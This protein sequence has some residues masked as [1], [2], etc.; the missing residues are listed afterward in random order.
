V[1]LSLA[2]WLYWG[3]RVHVGGQRVK[4]YGGWRVAWSLDGTTWQ[5]Y[6]T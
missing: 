6:R 4:G 1:P 3:G 2:N 5:R